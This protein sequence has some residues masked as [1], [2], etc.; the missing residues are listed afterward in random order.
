MMSLVFSQNK[1]KNTNNMQTKS[2]CWQQEKKFKKMC[3]KENARR[4]LAY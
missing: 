4:C 3:T 1:K 2:I